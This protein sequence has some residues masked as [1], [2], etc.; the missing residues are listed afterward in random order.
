MSQKTKPCRFFQ[1]GF[2]RF[3][4]QEC[5]FSHQNNSQDKQTDKQQ[6]NTVP[7]QD[8]ARMF[9]DKLRYVSKRN[10]YDE[11]SENKTQ[12]NKT[13]E[14]IEK[15]HRRNKKNTESFEPNYDP[16][17]MR[18]L[19][20]IAGKNKV[21]RLKF[22]SKDVVIV[23]D[24]FCEVDDLSIHEKLLDEMNRC[25][26]DSDCLWKLW[27]GDT[28]LIADDHTKFKERC[29]TFLKILNK[30]EEYFG[31]DIKATRFNLYRDDNDFK[32][33][34]HDAAAIDP[35]KAKVQNMTVGISFGRTREI[36]FQDAKEP[37]DHRR[38]VSFPL[39]NG[40]TYCFAKDIN[41]YWRH[42]V[43]AIPEDQKTNQSRISL[44]AWGSVKQKSV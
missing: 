7:R 3:T 42:G 35:E 28:H 44:I 4:D 22:Q 43:S 38:V 24:L 19:V 2:C 11:Y 6:V 20:E 32:P 25:G 31:M 18:V 21:S 39:P 26:I 1:Q 17:D 34:H 10:D 8:P 14:Q 40:Y 16:A 9:A 41:T 29:P 36:A 12:E 23:P 13:K 27:H 37:Q 5:K 33:F 30:I 15:T